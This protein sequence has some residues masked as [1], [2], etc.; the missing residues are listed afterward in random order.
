MHIGHI[1]GGQARRSVWRLQIAFACLIASTMLLTTAKAEASGPALC[2]AG[3]GAVT[4]YLDSFESAE[5]GWQVRH[6]TGSRGEPPVGRGGLAGSHWHFPPPEPGRQPWNGRLNIWADLFLDDE[7]DPEGAE[8]TIEMRSDPVVPESGR[9]TFIH[10]FDFTPLP[11][12]YGT[13]EYSLDSG[14]S[15]HSLGAFSERVDGHR[16]THLDLSG[17][18][19]RPLR[20]RFRVVTVAPL[21]GRVPNPGREFRGWA[22][23]DVHLY[24]C[25]DRN[26]EPKQKSTP[27][28]VRADG[29][30]RRLG[31]QFALSARRPFLL[32]RGTKNWLRAVFANRS[33][34]GIRNV[35]VCFRAPLRLVQGRR[36]A[37]IR[38]L[39]ARSSAELAFQVRV[40]PGI[41]PRRVRLMIRFVARHRDRT[42]ASASRRYRLSSG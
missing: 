25:T 18:T 17:H 1:I 11:G 36:C 35:R 16:A 22:I 14:R 42:L 8:S 27:P 10:R 19:G 7:N 2:P 23:D 29:A 38:K 40:R 26:L 28:P 31:Q 32:R 34:R 39:P 15:W 20:L 12:S 9:L 24:S 4:A 3:Q 6:L 13:V 37:V 21:E 5:L 41:A 30:A 33:S